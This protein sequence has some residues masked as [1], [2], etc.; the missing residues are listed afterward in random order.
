MDENAS[1]KIVNAEVPLSEMFGYATD[2]RSATQGRATYSMEFSK[3]GQPR[4][5]T[6]RRNPF[7]KAR[8]CNYLKLRMKED[9]QREI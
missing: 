5:V 1:G 4:R 2:L 7:L 9:V 6:S 8:R 3:Y